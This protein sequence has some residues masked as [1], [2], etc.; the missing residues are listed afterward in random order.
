MDTKTKTAIIIA[1]IGIPT[2]AAGGSFVLDFSNTTTIGQIG[3]NIINNYIEEN[4]GIDIE[5][6]KENCDAGEY[7]GQVAEQY[8]ELV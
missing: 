1:L 8:C 7:A 4:L 5:K 3:D 6:F 2:A